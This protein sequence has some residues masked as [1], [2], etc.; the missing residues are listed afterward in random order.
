MMAVVG[1]VN[2]KAIKH[3]WHA[4][5]HDGIA[6][7][8]TFVATLAFAPHLDNG[9][10]VGAGLAIV[11]YLYRTMSPRV[12]ILGR[13]TGRHPARRQGQQSADQRA[14]DRHAL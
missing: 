12:A 4:H 8:V 2:F 3:A 14:H 5:K 7:M 11:L 9:I 10:M 1:L 6:A 13:F